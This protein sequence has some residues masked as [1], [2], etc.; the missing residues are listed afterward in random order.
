MAARERGAMERRG[1]ARAR[2]THCLP[3][4]A[5]PDSPVLNA[6]CPQVS[7]SGL[8]RPWRLGRHG[9]D[10]G[11]CSL[12]RCVLLHQAAV[13]ASGVPSAVARASSLGRRRPHTCARLHASSTRQALATAAAVYKPPKHCSP[14]DLQVAAATEPWAAATP[15]A[16]SLPG[17][18]CALRHRV[19]HRL[20]KAHSICLSACLISRR[21]ERSRSPRHCLVRLQ[22]PFLRSAAACRPCPSHRPRP[23]RRR[24][25]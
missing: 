9:G 22:A 15:P 3:P 12:L 23:W 2:A 10:C 6:R 4:A 25:A 17:S 8:L 13:A 7:A 11:D 20:L 5:A 18:A 24:R 19:T 21:A 1:G 14:Q 16:R